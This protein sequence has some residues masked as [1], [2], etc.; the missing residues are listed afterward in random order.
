MPIYEFRCRSCN[1][2]TEKIC[3]SN[4]ENIPC[5]KCGDKALRIVSIFSAGPHTP[6]LSSPSCRPA[7]GG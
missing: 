1:S 2:L 7:G 4:V 5:P 3:R 6:E